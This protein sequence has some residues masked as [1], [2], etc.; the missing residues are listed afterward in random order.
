MTP[1]ATIL[2]ALQ[3]QNA[4]AFSAVLRKGE[5]GLTP[6]AYYMVNGLPPLTD[7]SRYPFGNI[8]T[9]DG[10]RASGAYGFIPHTWHALAA[11]YPDQMAGFT[12]PMQDF[13]ALADIA[14]RGAL[15]D[16]IAGRFDVAVAKLRPEW[17]S[18]PG[19]AETHWTLS[20]ARVLYEQHGGTYAPQPGAP[21]LP[22]SQEG[23]MPN[24]TTI[25]N[26][27]GA[28]APVIAAFNPIAGLIAGLAG[29][30][31]Q[32][33]APLAQ[34][35]L[36]KELARHTDHPEVAAQV[37]ATIVQAA[38]TATG[39]ADPIAAVVAAK[40]DPV[41]MQAV[42]VQAL[43][44]VDEIAPLLDRIADYSQRAGEANEARVT[45]AA[46]RR[47]ASPAD[48]RLAVF[49]GRSDVAMVS[50]VAL[51]LGV[52][53]VV[54]TCLSPAHTPD[55]TLM[56]LFSGVVGVILGNWGQVHNAEFGPRQD[57]RAVD[58][59]SAELAARRPK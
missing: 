16:V 33:F 48:A 19:A 36:T 8:S 58:A 35:K 37:A 41:V 38:Q 59:A 25:G 22:P 55:A 53:L 1:A 14:G 30:L 23:T 57:D 50:V 31:I 13:A 2:A 40:A 47:K 32:A 44:K 28:A 29:S 15:D 56:T 26:A 43:A 20:D 51:A 34:E 17:T 45:A 4:I 3:N 27:I 39:Q 11:L 18:L 52:A 46:V 6:A 42:Q 21:L 24:A 7:L 54:Q 10:G 9:N 12:P 49:L 5:S